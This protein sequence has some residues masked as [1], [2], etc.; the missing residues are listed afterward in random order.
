MTREELHSE[1]HRL[2]CGH[3]WCGPHGFIFHPESK[4]GLNIEDMRL[5]FWGCCA[6][7]HLD[8]AKAFEI[9]RALPDGAGHKRTCDSL[10]EEAGL[11]ENP[12]CLHVDGRLQ[13]SQTSRVSCG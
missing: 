13:S 9:L 7:T 12:H 6:N 5:H 1:L 2:N 4:G 3:K 8:I 10:R 11:P